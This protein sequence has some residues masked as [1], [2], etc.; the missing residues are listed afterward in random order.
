MSA[1]TRSCSS[2]GAE[3]PS[4]ARFCRMCGAPQEDA[5]QARDEAIE[6]AVAPAQP[7]PTIAGRPHFS[8]G[9]LFGVLV[10]GGV[11]AY[12]AYALISWDSGGRFTVTQTQVDGIAATWGTCLAVVDAKHIGSK[13]AVCAANDGIESCWR[14]DDGSTWLLIPVTQQECK[15]LIDATNKAVGVG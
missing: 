11:I 10:V 15:D 9:A 13:F 7:R 5:A 14:S 12:I 4:G 8:V 3:L 1:A 2:C 6:E